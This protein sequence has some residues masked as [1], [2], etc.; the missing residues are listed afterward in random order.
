MKADLTISSNK[1]F[2]FTKMLTTHINFTLNE[3][4]APV[5]EGRCQDMCGGD[6]GNEIVLYRQSS[7]KTIEDVGNTLKF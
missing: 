2:P 3:F 6:S 4:D 5:C 7:N 1:T